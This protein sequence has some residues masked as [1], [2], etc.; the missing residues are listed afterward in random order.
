MRPSFTPR[1]IHESP[2]DDPG[3]Y[4]SFS[5]KRRALLFDLGG[6]DSLSSRDILKTS[7]IFISHTHI[8][9][10]IG[11]DHLLRLFIG[12]EKTLHLFGP[13]GFL[14]NVEGKLAGF[15]W[16]LADNFEHSLEI[17]ATE[18]EADS[19]RTRSYNLKDRFQPKNEERATFTGLLVAEPGFNVEAAI[20][21]HGTPC[22]AFALTERFHV[23]IIKERLLEMGLSKG[24]WLNDF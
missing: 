15:C 19:L 6:L 23:N 5:L 22:L 4:I 24:P 9:H 17:R 14:A 13:K 10:F 3:L 16:N 12:R 7:H 18:V 2:F 11:F 21:D 1:L 8:D 20:V